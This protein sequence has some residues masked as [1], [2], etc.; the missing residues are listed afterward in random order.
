MMKMQKFGC[1]FNKVHIIVRI[2]FG[3]E[4]G[5]KPKNFKDFFLL[6]IS[7]HY[8]C[9]SVDIFVV[10][11]NRLLRRSHMSTFLNLVEEE[12]SFMLIIHGLCYLLSQ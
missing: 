12:R 10:L 7:L 3:M 11:K 8:W 2:S 6:G 5:I 1:Q 4:F 9:K